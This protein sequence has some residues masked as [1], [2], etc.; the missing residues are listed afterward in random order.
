MMTV[1]KNNAICLTLIGG[2]FCGYGLRWVTS[3]TQGEGTSE[4]KVAIPTTPSNPAPPTASGAFASATSSVLSAG[5]EL[6][7]C[8]R[9][10]AVCEA[11]GWDV[12]LDA[13]KLDT[14]LRRDEIEQR[15]PSSLGPFDSSPEAQQRFLCKL[16]VGSFG[17]SWA[18]RKNAEEKR[19]V[20]HKLFSEQV[21]DALGE[22]FVSRMQNL[23][24][25]A[26]DTAK[27]LLE[28]LDGLWEYQLPRIRQAA[29]EGDYESLLD[30]TI[31]LYQAEDGVVEKTLGVEAVKRFRAIMLKL[32][33]R[34]VA[35]I[36]VM[37]GLRW[38]KTL[39]W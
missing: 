12:A 21:Y 3:D 32:R 8:Q 24:L 26:P 36:A 31:A 13:M 17:R 14:N 35:M 1:K 27:V 34:N 7:N 16:T 22:Q 10:L 19:N 39:A 11:S 18:E 37:G 5:D 28:G 6:S 25:A 20:V 38:S 29:D 9:K 4:S 30:D 33:T 23:G 15:S 2:V